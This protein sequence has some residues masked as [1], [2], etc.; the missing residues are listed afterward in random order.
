MKHEDYPLDGK[1]IPYLNSLRAEGLTFNYIPKWTSKYNS[2][3]VYDYEPFCTDGFYVS[4]DLE[5]DESIVNYVMY[6]YDK[7]KEGIENIKRCFNG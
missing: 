7:R 5:G 2:Y 3:V 1:G 6:L 4:V